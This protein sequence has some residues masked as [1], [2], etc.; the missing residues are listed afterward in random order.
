MRAFVLLPLVVLA[1]CASSPK[2]YEK[3]SAIDVC[4]TAM[5]DPDAKPMAEAEI[6]RR[7]INCEPYSAELRKM[8]DQEMRAGGTVGAQDPKSTGAPTMGAGSGMGRY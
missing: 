2:D 6:R 7:N 4:Y 1:G 5:V 8:A 3:M